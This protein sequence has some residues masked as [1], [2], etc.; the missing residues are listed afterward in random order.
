MIGSVCFIFDRV[1]RILK[2]RKYRNL[3][4]PYIYTGKVIQLHYNADNSGDVFNVRILTMRDGYM[5]AVKLN[6]SMIYKITYEKYYKYTIQ[7]IEESMKGLG[8]V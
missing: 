3:V 7:P 2:D 5:E 1:K 8:S 4:K 6:T